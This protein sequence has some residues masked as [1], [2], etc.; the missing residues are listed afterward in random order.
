[1][2]WLL[3]SGQ[4]SIDHI[5]GLQPL[6][7]ISGS[8]APAYLYSSVMASAS[9]SNLPKSISKGSIQHST[10]SGVLSKRPREPGSDGSDATTT[11]QGVIQKNSSGDLLRAHGNSKLHPNHPSNKDKDGFV[12]SDTPVNNAS[13]ATNKLA[14]LDA[15]AQHQFKVT[16]ALAAA[17]ASAAAA[18]NGVSMVDYSNNFDNS[19]LFSSSYHNPLSG[20]DAKGIGGVDLR[21]VAKCPVCKEPVAGVR[22]APHLERCLSGGKRAGLDALLSGDILSQSARGAAGDNRS[23]RAQDPYP[24]SAIVRVRLNASGMAQGLPK[25]N[26]DRE[27]VS[28]EEWERECTAA[29]KHKT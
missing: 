23:T 1:M 29:G 11:A 25:A 9:I 18:S 17:T 13:S 3:K 6:Q 12:Q 26:Q 4:L 10:Q 8:D 27:G 28:I 19:T 21:Q 14:A 20:K 24:R 7:L 16:A 15:Q 22:F 5:Y 2:H